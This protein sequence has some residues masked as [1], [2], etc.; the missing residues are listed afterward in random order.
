MVLARA[1]GSGGGDRVCGSSCD[2]KGRGAEPDIRLS[3]PWKFFGAVCKD[4]AEISLPDLFST[5]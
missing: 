2:V 1:G 3:G 5:A 4:R